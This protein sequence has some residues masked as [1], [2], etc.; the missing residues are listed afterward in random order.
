MQETLV[1]QSV[2]DNLASCPLLLPEILIA[3]TIGVI[4]VLTGLL[5]RYQRYWLLPVA[6]L[7]TIGAWYSTY[8]LGSYL[9]IRSTR[10]LFNQLLT[11]DPLAVFFCLLLL[12]ITLFLLFVPPQQTR[13]SLNTTHKPI[14]VVLILVILLGSCLLVMAFHWL[15]IYLSLT[16]LSLAS[17]LLIG[18]HQTPHSIEGSL[19]YLLYSMATTAVM[20]WGMAHFYGFTGTLALGDP[21]L[22]FILQT[23]P[24]YI[25]LATLGL[26]I[27]GLLATIAAVPYHFWV[28]DVYQGA[29]SA[30]VSCL[31]TMPRLA[32]V[33]VFLR[34]FQQLLPQLEAMLQM[35][36][37]HGM[38]TLALLTLIVGH[39]A[40]L[41]QNN[42][43]R[44][45]AYG[46]VAQ[47]GLLMAGI[48]A[49]KSNPIAVWYYSAVYGIMGLA[50]WVGIK[51]LQRLT[52]SRHLQEYAGLGRKFPLLGSSIT[53]T[54]F[55]LIGLPPTAGFTG[56]L[57]IFTA[58]W[59]HVQRTGSFVFGA[60]LMASLLGTIF[61]LY[62]YLK[63]PYLLFCK[64]ARQPMAA[65]RVQP[66]DQIVLGC[67]A[68]LLLVGFFAASSLL[69]ALGNWCD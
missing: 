3:V 46:S 49:S 37:Q 35:K 36:M 62:Y 31:S 67:L 6:L 15:T 55:A 38:A 50:A 69:G 17:A 4:L 23:V 57:L 27:S 9:V 43:Q 19:K 21:N 58:L 28:P 45:F 52:G 68:T 2:L 33:A 40:A 10:P 42:G 12:S 54:V 16:L 32:T 22:K 47:G 56:K 44:L 61:S 53:L 59:D 11:L 29:P 30:V 13:L 26:C 51:I 24:E 7:G 25:V 60:L 41:V 63:L 14:Y 48:A 20:L 39:T 5:P 66:A 34:L 18:S 1:I 8:R 64:A 65:L